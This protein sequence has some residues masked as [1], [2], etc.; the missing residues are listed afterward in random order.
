MMATEEIDYEVPT[1]SASQIHD[2]SVKAGFLWKTTN[3]AGRS[4]SKSQYFVLTKSS[5]DQYKSR[6]CVSF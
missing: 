3:I 6:L 2:V 5:L 1:I 4:T